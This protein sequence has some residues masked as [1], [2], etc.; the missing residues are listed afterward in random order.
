MSLRLRHDSLRVPPREPWARNRFIP[1]FATFTIVL[2]GLWLGS[3][4]IR[5]RRVHPKPEEGFSVDTR[6]EVLLIESGGSHDEVA[7]AF[8]YALASIQGLHTYMYLA[9]PR[10]RIEN[11]YEWLRRRYK[12]STYS[13]SPLYALHSHDDLRLPN[14]IILVT[15]EH[16][17]YSADTMLQYYFDHGSQ[18]HLLICVIHHVDRFLA[19]EE[20]LRRWARTNRLHL[21]TLSTHTTNEL[22]K[23]LEGHHNGLY[24]QTSVDTFPPIF[25]VPLNAAAPETDRLA[26]VLQGNFDDSRRS[27]L[28]TLLEFE[29]MVDELPPPIASRLELILAGNG[30]EVGIPAKIMPYVSVNFSLEYIPYYNLL[31]QSFALVPAFADESYYTSKASSSVPASL[32]ANVPIMGSQ[33]LLDK[34]G[35]LTSESIWLE[36]VAGE[37]EMSGVYELLRRHFDDHGHERRSWRWALEEKR[38]GVRKRALELMVENG[39]LMRAIVGKEGSH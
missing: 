22:L 32:I 5:S 3:Q 7:A 36:D 26:V 6:Q 17:L 15:C 13:I 28:K 37:S 29:R 34:Y 30:K 4:L 16:D 19:I 12:L 39:R 1:F 35:Y 9:L 27:Y 25:P 24:L 20:R 33:K 21:L 31:H 14:A 18:E 11:V 2:A 8:Y 23:E 10:F 38:Q